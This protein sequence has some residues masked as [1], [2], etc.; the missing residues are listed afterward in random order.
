VTQREAFR[1][2]NRVVRPFVKLG[3][4]GPPPFGVGTIVVATTGRR[5]GLSRE[6]PLAGAR[7]GDTVVVS[8]VRGDSEWIRNL[9]ADSDATL[10]L[11]GCARPVEASIQRLPGLS[12]AVLRGA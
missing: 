4:G 12:V 2:L 6:V 8:T 1:A 5:S 7:V 11:D 9:E 10:W 3:V